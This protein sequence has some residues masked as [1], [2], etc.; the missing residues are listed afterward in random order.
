MD[1]SEK[2]ILRIVDANLNRA[3]EGLRVVEEL[4]RFVLEDSGLQKRTKSLRHALA[5]LFRSS[6][7]SRCV[8]SSG[9]PSN[10]GLDR[11]RLIDWGRDALAGGESTRKTTG[12]F[13]Q[14]NFSRVEESLRALEEFSKRFSG[15]LSPRLCSLRF[16]VYAL[17]QDYVRACNRVSNVR[18]LRK[19]GLYPILD[20]EAIPGQ[21]PLKVARQ[22]LA[23]GVRIVQYRDKTSTSAEV[24]EI[25]SALRHL[26]SRRKV[27]FIV[28]DRVDVAEAVNADGVHLGQDD[29]PV[30]LARKMLGS[31]KVIGKS[32]HSFTQARGAAKEDVDYLA[33]GPI[34]STPTK[35]GARP[36]GLEL[37]AKVRKMTDKPIVGIGGIDQENVGGILDAGADAAAVISAVLKAKCVRASAEHLVEICRSRLGNKQ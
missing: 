9:S 11:E 18:S 7:G 28:N 27:V 10:R 24:C 33:V 17:E 6:R 5:S 2:E 3:R 22:V 21:D 14:A 26:T 8:G 16:E 30:A 13:V 25:C 19:I 32:T 31:R 37:I 12:D 15:G 34:F 4:S 35:P 23:P 29:V 36:V 1:I 20:R